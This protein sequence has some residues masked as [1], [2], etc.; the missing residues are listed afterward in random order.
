MFFKTAKFHL[1]G[2]LT[3]VSV[4]NHKLLLRMQGGR[5]KDI[6]SIYVIDNALGFGEI[7]EISTGHRLW[8]S[9]NRKGQ[10]QMNDPALRRS[11]SEMN[12]FLFL[13]SLEPTRPTKPVPKRSMVAGSGTGADTFTPTSP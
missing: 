4:Q 6:Q 9:R 12:Y 7:G 1:G 11:F 10:N 5:L 2:M 3:F 8:G 13:R